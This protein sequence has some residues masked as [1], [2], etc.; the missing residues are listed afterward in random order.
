MNEFEKARQRI[1]DKKVIFE[2][3]VP[4]LLE[5]ESQ[6]FSKLPERLPS[7]IQEARCQ[8][9]KDEGV[10]MVE[11]IYIIYAYSQETYINLC[12]EITQLNGNRVESW[13]QGL[14]VIDSIDHDDLGELGKMEWVRS[15]FNFKKGTP[16][17]LADNVAVKGGGWVAS[18]VSI[19]RVLFSYYKNEK[20]LG[21]AFRIK[22]NGK[23]DFKGLGKEGYSSDFTFQE[24]QG[25]DLFVETL[26]SSLDQREYVRQDGK[27]KKSNIKTD[28]EKLEKENAVS[29]QSVTDTS[30]PVEKGVANTIELDQINEARY[31]EME[32]EERNRVLEEIERRE[33][34]DPSYQRPDWISQDE[35]PQYFGGELGQ[36]RLPNDTLSN[37]DS[38]Q[39]ATGR[40]YPR[41]PENG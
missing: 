25:F 8:I 10:T 35:K 22:S 6:F 27:K 12:H 3:A 24:D 4:Q 41:P 14:R 31:R 9:E 40:N 37:E 13:Q 29:R 36:R 39:T 15:H 7:V 21:M 38:F 18:N 19:D 5:M 26:I 33:A 16:E 2:S 1:A 11:S 30:S 20:N 17:F 28:E 23:V 34:S 32:F